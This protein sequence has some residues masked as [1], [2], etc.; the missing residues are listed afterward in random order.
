MSRVIM[1]ELRFPKNSGV[2]LTSVRGKK[3][4][5]VS[6]GFF[7]RELYLEFK[8]AA[9]HSVPSE[10]EKSEEEQG[11]VRGDSL[12]GEGLNEGRRADAGQQH[13]RV[14]QQFVSAAVESPLGAGRSTGRPIGIWAQF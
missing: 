5:S 3:S 13:A 12:G 9:A 14:P 6:E 11:P 1:G 10:V 8:M 7:N 2:A 4:A